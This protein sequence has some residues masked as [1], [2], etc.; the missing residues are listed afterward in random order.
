MRD[1]GRR[2][3][4]RQRVAAGGGSPGPKQPAAAQHLEGRPR[5]SST[6]PQTTGS[7]TQPGVRRPVLS[8][9][10]LP[11]KAGVAP[12]PAKDPVRSQRPP[13]PW[14]FAGGLEPT[15]RTVRRSRTRR[16]RAPPA[17]RR[18]RPR[19]YRD[20]LRGT[21]SI[22]CRRRPPRSCCGCASSHAGSFT[23]HQLPVH[24]PKSARHDGV[25]RS[26]SPAPLLIRWSAAAPSRCPGVPLNLEAEPAGSRPANRQ[27]L[28][29]PKPKPGALEEIDRQKRERLD[30]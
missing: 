20:C 15:V 26:P 22:R 4:D 2:R 28:P 27:Q 7:A 18:D 10:S 12:G 3:A 23:D 5:R 21:A 16:R 8:L 14:A 29:T 30:W 1:I 6:V 19:T 9:H 13:L 17:R 11:L 24:E 25:R